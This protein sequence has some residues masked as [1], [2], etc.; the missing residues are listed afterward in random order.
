MLKQSKRASMQALAMRVK[1]GIQRGNAG[2]YA[3]AR[4]EKQTSKYVSAWNGKKKEKIASVPVL[5]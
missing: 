3:R 4:K 5:K 1:L 2:K